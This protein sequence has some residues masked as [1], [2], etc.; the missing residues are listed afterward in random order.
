MLKTVNQIE[1][2]PPELA[3]ILWRWLP[4][5]DIWRTVDGRMYI[6]GVSRWRGKVEPLHEIIIYIDK[7][8]TPHLDPYFAF[9]VSGCF[10][11]IASRYV[12]AHGDPWAKVDFSN[13]NALDDFYKLIKKAVDRL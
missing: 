13:P 7:K 8:R 4:T 3:Y 12:T 6:K 10:A 1:E 2:P 9:Y 5:I 11:E